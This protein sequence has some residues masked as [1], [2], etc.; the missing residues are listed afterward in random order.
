MLVSLGISP[1]STSER[2][3]MFQ[4]RGNN[5]CIVASIKGKNMLPIILFPLKVAPMRKDTILKDFKL[6]NC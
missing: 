2:C 4:R 1:K 6:R 5:V 3:S